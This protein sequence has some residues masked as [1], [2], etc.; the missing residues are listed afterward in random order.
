MLDAAAQN[1]VDVLKTFSF[2]ELN[3]IVEQNGEILTVLHQAC[4]HGSF[5][6]IKYLHQRHS[7][8]H[9]QGYDMVTHLL[10]PAGLGFSGW[11]F[12]K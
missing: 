1:R 3:S 12:V 4:K 8:S 2:E 9:K 7:H 10:L 6:V 11:F 5:E